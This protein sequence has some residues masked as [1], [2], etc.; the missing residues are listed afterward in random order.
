MDSQAF[1]D[2]NERRGKV[3]A[4]LTQLLCSAPVLILHGCAKLPSKREIFTSRR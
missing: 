3:P 1:Y 4:R 2:F